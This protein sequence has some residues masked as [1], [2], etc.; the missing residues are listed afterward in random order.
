MFARSGNKK[1]PSVSDDSRDEDGVHA[2]DG[3]D[4]DD[5]YEQVS[6]YLTVYLCINLSTYISIYVSIYNIFHI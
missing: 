3:D 6:I 2:M 5:E 4:D 1:N